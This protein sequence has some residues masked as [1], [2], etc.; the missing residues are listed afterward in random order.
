MMFRDGNGG[1]LVVRQRCNAERV[2]ARRLKPVLD[3]ALAGAL[4]VPL[5]PFALV[6]GVAVRASL[7]PPVLYRQTRVGR[8]GE[9]FVM[10]KFRTMTPDRRISMVPFEGAERRV[11]FEATDDPR[12]TRLGDLLRRCS[13]DEVPQLWNIVRGEMSLVG[14]RPEVPPAVETYPEHAEERHLVRPGLTGLWQVTA[15]G[16]QPMEQGVGVDIEYV[17]RVSF[18]LDCWILY[19]TLPVVLGSARRPTP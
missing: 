5:A 18:R 14:P 7:G 8:G 9:P 1:D 17:R 10:L 19:R 11:S 16:T 4:L 12:H 2:Y 6:I 15:R 3:R 13:L